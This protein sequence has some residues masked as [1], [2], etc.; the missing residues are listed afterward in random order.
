M[1]TF[2]S[3]GFSIFRWNVIVDR[4][5]TLR[6]EQL[7]KEVASEPNYEEVLQALGTIAR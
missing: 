3:R 1:A 4:E 5:G 7:V 2:P 6:Y